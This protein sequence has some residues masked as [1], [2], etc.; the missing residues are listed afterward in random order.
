MNLPPTYNFIKYRL[1]K[2]NPNID[3]TELVRLVVSETD[4][5]KNLLEKSKQ[6]ILLEAHKDLRKNY[7]IAET[8]SIARKTANVYLFNL[9]VKELKDLDDEAKERG[10]ESSILIGA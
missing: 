1:S 4:S 2:E 10:R 8:M 6:K 9:A 7:S 5:N 3:K